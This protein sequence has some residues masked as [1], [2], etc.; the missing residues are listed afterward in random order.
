MQFLVANES[1]NK[2][3]KNLALNCKGNTLVLFQYVEK[4]GIPLYEAIKA[5]AVDK[6]IYIVHGGIETLDREDIRKNT[7]LGDNTIIVASY[8]TFSTGE[9]PPCGSA[10]PNALCRTLTT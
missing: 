10:A 7:E 6:N 8:A 5:K 1:R 2:F 9:V 3:I 4:H